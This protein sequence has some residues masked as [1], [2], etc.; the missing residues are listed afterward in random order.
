M[1]WKDQ[2]RTASFRNVT[3]KVDTAEMSF[4]RRNQLH[5][6][7]QKDTPFSEDLGRKAREYTF[8]AYIIGDN[9]FRNRDALI[10]AIEGSKE[11]ATLIHPTLG[12]KRV[13]PKECR[14]SFNNKQGGIEFFTLTFVEAGEKKF[15][16]GLFNTGGL[17]NLQS[18][19]VIDK[20]GS[21]VDK[22]YNTLDY[23]DNVA[24]KATG[25]VNDFVGTIESALPFARIQETFFSP[26]K[27][28]ISTFKSLIPTN[29]SSSNLLRGDVVA[30]SAENLS[31][32]KVGIVSL[33]TGISKV[34]KNSHEVL[35]VQKRIFQFGSSYP[36]VIKT[37]PSSIQ[38][39]KNQDAIIDLVRHV[40]IAKMAEA[41]QSIEFLSKQD[42]VETRDNILED[43]D[44]AITK[45]GN[46]GADEIYQALVSL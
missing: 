24:S 40:A 35:R 6:Y 1:G 38:E 44:Q 36:A 29:I 43:L 28:L 25:L 7:P 4:G 45:A 30:S 41:T 37:T 33:V 9:Y 2:L 3:F 8:N 19:A 32:S 46:N 5:E 17:L 16:S 21:Y 22:V 18:I 10:K 34:C 26:F 42:A 39:S 31:V 13:I 14:T 11:P 12:N 20:I 15:P 23:I 27:N